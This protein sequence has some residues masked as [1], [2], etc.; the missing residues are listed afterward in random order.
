MV[1]KKGNKV[2]IGKTPWNK[3][4]IGKDY[5]SHYENGFGGTFQKGITPHNKGVKGWM[6]GHIGY[7][8]GKKHSEETKRKMSEV[9]KDFI[10]WNKGKSFPQISGENHPSWKGGITSL[11]KQIRKNFRYRQWRDDVYTRDDFTCQICGIRGRRLNAHHI[12]SFSSILQYY[13]ITNLEEA[14][15]CD[16]IFNI[17][18]GITLCKECHID[19][20]KIK[21]T[22]G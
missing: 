18:N 1:F 11:D 6:K 10:P 22:A 4:L 12:K 17:N 20:H 21:Q 19:I 3:G 8:L 14:I 16:E 15:E 9:K 2:N 7:M 5:K 13:E